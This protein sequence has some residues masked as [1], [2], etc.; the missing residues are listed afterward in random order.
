M[1]RQP[2]HI[3]LSHAV[4]IAIAAVLSLT[5][6]AGADAAET[7]TAT[8]K[9]KTAGGLEASAPVS[10][11]VERFSSDAERDE[12]VAAL[13]QGGTRARDLLFARNPIGS[14]VV[15]KTNTAIKYANVRTTGDGRLITVITATP[16]AFIG[17]GLPGA[18]PKTGFDLGLV[19]LKVATS[20]AGHGELVPATKVKFNELGAIVTDDYSEEVVTLSNVIAKK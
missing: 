3:L 7:I 11:V 1:R 10:V 15:G 14:V 20:G 2:S 16:I 8:A 5:L 12:L 19:M 17:A 6:P 13:K 9:L 18:Q 4:S